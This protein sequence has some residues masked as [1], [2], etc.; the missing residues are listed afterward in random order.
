MSQTAYTVDPAVGREGALVDASLAKDVLS[1]AAEGAI[2]AGR[3]VI[4]GTSVGRQA[5]VPAASGDITANKVLGVTLYD[6]AKE[7]AEP[8]FADEDELPILASGK[9]W[10]LTEDAM[11]AG[12]PVFVRHTAGGAGQVPGRIRSDLDTNKAIALPEVRLLT[13]SSGVDGLV[14]VQLN[15]P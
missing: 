6:A 13:S 7:T 11:T 8:E 2:N 12:N 5:K 15:L 9:V 4:N 14:Q 1:R 10:M 3:F